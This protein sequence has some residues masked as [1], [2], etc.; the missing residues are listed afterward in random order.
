MSNGFLD[1]Y[2]LYNSNNE[3]PRSYHL[4]S[5][6]AVL[7]SAASRRI[8]IHQGYFLV[9]P[10]LYIC[11]VG[12]QGARKTTAKDQAYD[13][14]REALKD[15]LPVS[16]ES[17]SKEAITQ[18]M[19]A[20]PQIRKYNCP[21]TNEALEYRPFT[22]FCTEL[23]N[24]LSINPV[25]MLDFLTTI[26]DRNYYDVITKNKGTDTIMRPSVT[27]LACE[28]PEWI[29]ERL[30]QQVISG[31]FSRR[32]VFV[33]ELK[34]ERKIAF[35]SVSVEMAQAYAR[36]VA[37]LKKLW[38][39]V[40]EFTWEPDAKVFY[41]KWYNSLEI[42][43]NPLMA[44]FYESKHVQALKV[45]MLLAV[46]KSDM[47]LILTRDILVEAISY[48]NMIEPNMAKLAD[49]YGGNKL[50]APGVRAVEIIEAFGG[51]MKRS[52][53]KGKM[54]NDLQGRDFDEVIRHYVES[55]LLVEA[56]KSNPANPEVKIKYLLTPAKAAEVKKKQEG[57]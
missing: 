3:A 2:L 51:E 1:D 46:C 7:A 54:W 29:T 28:T 18:F 36:C 34:R 4:W 20:D 41:E 30:K 14:L 40:G 6:F 45:A 13:M 33:Y 52:E 11:L 56:T 22:I 16:A 43:S 8:W 53:L 19:A 25:V 27:F 57:K 37:H 47:R 9:Y 10:N 35:P 32:V 12:K 26:Y 24:F 42:P 23:K 49:G 31:G 55:G 39:L 5:A 17:M 21:K 15:E 44:G 48:L 38:S 50:A